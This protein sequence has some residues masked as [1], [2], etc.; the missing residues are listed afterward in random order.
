MTIVLTL[1]WVFYIAEGKTR[2][3]TPTASL[4]SMTKISSGD[5]VRQLLYGDKTN[6]LLST[7]A[8][9]VIQVS[10]AVVYV[11]VFWSFFSYMITAFHR[12]GECLTLPSNNVL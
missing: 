9:R 6:H 10:V 8:V 3:A 1:F 7:H 2:I 11:S 12:E 5:H 4:T